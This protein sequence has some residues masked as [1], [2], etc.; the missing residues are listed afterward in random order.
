MSVNR[1]KC[2]SKGEHHDCIEC[3]ALAFVQDEVNM[4]CCAI[5]SSVSNEE[6]SARQ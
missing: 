4:H 1:N 3:A 6:E 5:E 2:W